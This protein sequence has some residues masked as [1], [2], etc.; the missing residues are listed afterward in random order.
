MKLKRKKK[1]KR[2]ISYKKRVGKKIM[3]GMGFQ[4]GDKYQ[5]HHLI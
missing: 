3:S 5:E 2:E 4:R 1:R